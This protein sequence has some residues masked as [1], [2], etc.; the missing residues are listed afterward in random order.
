MLHL[1]RTMALCV[2]IL[3]AATSAAFA[4]ATT[5]PADR[6]YRSGVIFTADANHPSAEAIAIRDRRIIYVGGN[7]GVLRY[8]SAATID[9]DLKGR[10]LMPGLIDGH[11]HPLEAGATL[12]KC[13]LH[14]ASLTVTEL[15]QR[16]QACLDQ[17]KP[18]EPDEWLEVVSWFQESMRPAGVKTNHA[19]LDLLKTSRPI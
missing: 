11:M 1:P 3:L 6:I 8:I 17:T 18:Q 9:V 16:V 4:D 12:L 19:M 14:Y 15:Q 2:S 7:Q 13:N 5:A 10:F